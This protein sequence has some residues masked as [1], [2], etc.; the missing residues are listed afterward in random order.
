[1][2]RLLDHGPSPP[3]WNMIVDSILLR[4]HAEAGG[5]PTLRFYEWAR[6][7]LSLGAAQKLP[8]QLSLAHL[9]AQGLV[10]VRRPTGGR[11][12]L[13]GGD[14]T[15]SIVAGAQE[16]FKPSVTAVYRRLCR[17]LQAGLARLGVRALPGLPQN[18]RAPGFNCFAQ[19]ARG[20][21]TWQGRK[22]MGSAQVW[23]GSSFLQHG[24]IL[25]IPVEKN[26]QQLLVD[27]IQEAAEAM[28]S[29]ADIMGASPPLTTLKAA[30]LQG[31]QEELG[32]TLAAGEFT[33]WEISNLTAELTNV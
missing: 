24:A 27:P 28:I 29:L 12:V 17:G 21:L 13:H 1:M 23:Q 26:R 14:L 5:P 10:V 15:Y 18:C 9:T 6:P 11:A 31:L 22:F 2:W 4:S 16:G 32:I 19:T 20:D 7:T 25:V 30:L 3:L 8:E 33:P